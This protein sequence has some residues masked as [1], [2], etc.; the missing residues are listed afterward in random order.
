MLRY[1][2]GLAEVCEA[3]FL[4]LRS[5]WIELADAVVSLRLTRVFLPCVVPE[6]HKADIQ[7]SRCNGSKVR[8]ADI[9][10]EFWIAA[11]TAC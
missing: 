4:H 8:S 10:V 5:M 3:F 6:A 11:K 7:E 9:D 2:K 1:G